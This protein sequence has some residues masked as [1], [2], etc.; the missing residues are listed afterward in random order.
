MGMHVAVNNSERC[1]LLQNDAR[2]IAEIKL[3]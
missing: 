2:L 1:E 3:V